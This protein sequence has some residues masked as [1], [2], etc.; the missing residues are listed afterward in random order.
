M[1]WIFA[2][3]QDPKVLFYVYTIFYIN[4]TKESLMQIFFRKF[5]YN[6]IYT[7][8]QKNHLSG[9]ENAKISV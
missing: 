6:L 1:N 9:G 8:V 4:N 5:P 3:S 2:I 7:K